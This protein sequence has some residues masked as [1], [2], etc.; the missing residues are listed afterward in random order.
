MPAWTNPKAEAAAARQL[1]RL[2][3]SMQTQGEEDTDQGQVDDEGRDRQRVPHILNRRA[4]QLGRTLGPT[5]PAVA[6]A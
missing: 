1:A 4:Q 3:D 6:A 2:M 5:A